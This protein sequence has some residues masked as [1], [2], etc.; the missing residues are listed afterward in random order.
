MEAA[1]REAHEDKSMSVAMSL[2]KRKMVMGLPDKMTR[3]E[4]VAGAGGPGQEKKDM[5]RQKKRIE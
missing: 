5:Q 3:Q 2:G 4:E 1:C